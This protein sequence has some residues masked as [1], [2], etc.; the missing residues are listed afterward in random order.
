MSE[1]IWWFPM[2]II[3]FFICCEVTTSLLAIWNCL[4]W[5]EQVPALH[6]ASHQG[7][8]EL[9]AADYSHA[10]TAEPS[11]LRKKGILLCWKHYR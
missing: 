11:E 10:R 9:N 7:G 1:D 2:G 3:K 5:W 4:Y 8:A 6:P